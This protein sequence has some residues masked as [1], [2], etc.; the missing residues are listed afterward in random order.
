MIKYFGLTSLSLAIATA[1][2][3][4]VYAIDIATLA[5]ANGYTNLSVA[6]E[7][8]GRIVGDQ[9]LNT[10][11]DEETASR[12][13]GDQLL[14][15]RVDKETAS[16]ITGDIATLAFANGYTNLSV[17][18]ERD[19]RIVADNE[20][21]LDRQKIREELI[22]GDANTLSQS[23]A[24]T[25]QSF[26]KMENRYQASIAASMAIASLPQPTEA[27]FSMLSFGVGQWESEQGYA[28]GVSGVTDNNKWVYK[29]AGTSNSRGNFGGSVSFGMQW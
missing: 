22:A 12:I 6:N 26:N 5:F 9:L 17:A 13:V 3:S 23:K 1:T 10:R 20:A 15:T 7:R 27:G 8:N 18:N 21:I 29:A 19:N 11:V 14:N 28:L 4:N 16:R 25:D 2:T 24:Y